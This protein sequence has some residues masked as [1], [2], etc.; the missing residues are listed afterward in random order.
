MAKV[1]Y[2]AQCGQRSEITRKAVKGYGIV[3][4]IEPHICHEEPIPLDL[5]PIEIPTKKADGEFVRNL[6]N[7]RPA[8]I[9]SVSTMDLK[10]RRPSQDVKSSAPISLLDQFKQLNPSMPEGEL[11]EPEGGE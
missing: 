2:C 6:D 7:L 11:G 3:D 4:I 10:D 8:N 5:E 9:G 1:V